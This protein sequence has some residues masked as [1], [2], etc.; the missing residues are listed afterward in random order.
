[1][2]AALAQLLLPALAAWYTSDALDQVPP[3]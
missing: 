2:A 1:M 3:V